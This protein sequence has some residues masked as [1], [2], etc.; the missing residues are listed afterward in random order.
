MLQSKMIVLLG[1]LVRCG[2]DKKTKKYDNK[3]SGMPLAKLWSINRYAKQCNCGLLRVEW[4]QR[5][6][7]A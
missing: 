2:D 4:H 5:N 1:R 3:L 7:P 6:R